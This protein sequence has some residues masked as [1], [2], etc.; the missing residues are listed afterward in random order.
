MI[1]E[2]S[3]KMTNMPLFTGAEIGLTAGINSDGISDDY[4]LLVNKF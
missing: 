4:M 2:L 3:E 1:D